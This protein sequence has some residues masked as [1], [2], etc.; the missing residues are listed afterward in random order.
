MLL[1]SSNG[2]VLLVLEDD[3]A[4]FDPSRTR[5]PGFGLEGMSERVQLL[6]GTLELSSRES[7]GTSL[8]V[9]VPLR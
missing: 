1:G 8:V 7:G 2:T 5:G 3:G 6:G 9:E 4:G